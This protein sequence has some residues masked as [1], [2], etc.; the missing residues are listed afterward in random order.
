MPDMDG[1]QLTKKIRQ[2]F[3]IEEL[4]IIGASAQDY[5]N[6]SARFLK[7]GANDF[8]TKPFLSEEFY[9]RV[10]MNVNNLEY[11][12]INKEL[13]VRDFLTDLYNRRYFYE[14]GQKLFA[15][16]KRLEKHLSIAM[17]DIDHFKK[18]NDTYGHDGGDKVLI[19]ISQVLKNRFRASDIV[20][21]FGGEEFCIFATDMNPDC[22]VKI[23]EELRQTVKDT[24]IIHEDKKINVTISIGVCNMR[25][26]TLEEMV[27]EA[28]RK[29]YEAK[30][31][32][33]DRVVC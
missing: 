13:S 25:A 15:S 24:T 23:F 21:R 1:F 27:K 6:M 33:R 16:S 28:D 3:N 17:L 12:Q 8:L 14:I 11:I 9:C 19:A 32:G 26:D 5:K 22:A 4:A 18:I 2:K 7:F 20:S 31:G 29:L 30:N 10:T